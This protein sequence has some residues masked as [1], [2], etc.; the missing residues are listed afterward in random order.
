MPKTLHEIPR[1]RP[2]TPLLDRASSPAELRRLGE[3]D[4]ET[5]ADELRQYLLYTV[6]QTGGHFGAG[7]G[8]VELTI[9]LHYV[10]DTP[11]DRLVWDVG[12]QAYPHKILTERRELMGTLRQKNGLAAFP[13]R[14]ESE[15]DTFG[16][17]HSS[18]SISAA[19][20]M[21]IAARLQGKERKSVAVIGDG[22]LTAGMAFEALNHASEVDADMLVILNDNDMSISH[23]VG[24]LSNYLAKILSSRTYSSMREGSKKVLSRLPGAWEI[25]RRTE[26]YAKGMLVPGTLFEELGW[27]YIGPIDGHDLPTLVATL[28]NMRDMKGPQFLHVVTKKGKGFAPAELDPIGYHAI[29]K[30]EA[31]GSAPKKT[32]GPKYSSVFGQWLCDMA[33]QDARLLGITPAMKEGSDLVAFSERY[34]ERYFDVAIAEQHAVTLAAGMACEGMKPVVAIYSTFLQRAY[35]QLI[36]DV[37]VQHLDVLF[38]IDRAGLVG[39]DGPTHAG[40]FDISYLRCIPGMLV[41]TPSDEDE[42]RKLLTTGYLF[43]GPAAVRYPRGSGPNHPIDPD[44]QPVEIGKGVVRRRGG[45]VALLVFGV[46]LAEAMKV[47][48]S[49]DATVVDMRFVKPLDEA[50]V[51]ELAG[52]HEQLLVTIE[53]NAVMGGAGS[54]VGE[55]LAS[56][57]LEVPLLQLGLPD[58]YVEH[59]KPSEMLAECGLDAAGIEKAVRQRLDRQ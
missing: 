46:Q 19:L 20:G 38:A 18:T 1:E 4:L 26:E 52:S 35:D 14:A 50:L 42:L 53:E 55:F 31:P 58:Y 54:A 56:E 51:R 32:G 45:R 11:D 34:P 49:L 43:D 21:A 59:A 12:H 36:H 40:S 28:R 33:A 29:T 15:Y 10:F 48:E 22:A 16:V 25:A 6:G 7:L 2:A 13:R 57:G 37:A 3:A 30:L 41:M 24:G 39:E 17:G 9:A 44:L 27:N 23:N 47:A 5:L 8:V